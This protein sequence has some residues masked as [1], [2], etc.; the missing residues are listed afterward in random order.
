MRQLEQKRSKRTYTLQKP[1]KKLWREWKVKNV[2]YGVAFASFL[3][4]VALGTFATC[5]SLSRAPRIQSELKVERKK[6]FA[7]CGSL[8]SE[9]STKAKNHD[10]TNECIKDYDSCVHEAKSKTVSIYV[11]VIQII[12]LTALAF[13]GCAASLLNISLNSP[14]KTTLNDETK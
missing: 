9:C 4:L 11:N 5:N 3:P 1:R 13:V 14:K 6:H 8:V 2:F 12:S 10:E 7:K